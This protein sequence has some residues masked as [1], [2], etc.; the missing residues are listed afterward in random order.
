M[1]DLPITA[2]SLADIKVIFGELKLLLESTGFRLRKW[3]ANHLAKPILLS[4]PKCDLCS[5]IQEIDLGSNLMPDFKELGLICDME[6]D[7][8]KVYYNKNLTMPARLSRR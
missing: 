3:S 7:C 1:D 6:K 8:F 4:I 2:S 5:N